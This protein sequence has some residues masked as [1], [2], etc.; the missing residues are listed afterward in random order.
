M[1]SSRLSCG[2]LSVLGLCSAGQFQAV[3]S[4]TQSRHLGVNKHLGSVTVLS[5]Q[6]RWRAGYLKAKP[7]LVR[8]GL[9]KQ[10]LALLQLSVVS[11]VIREGAEGLQGSTWVFCLRF[12]GLGCPRCIFPQSPHLYVL[13]A[14]VL[15]QA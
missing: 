2:L 13:A 9:R 12:A 7:S 8:A 15:C 4:K 5:L 3:L 14:P 10:R 1:S 6:T 11:G